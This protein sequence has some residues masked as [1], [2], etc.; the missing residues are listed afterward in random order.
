MGSKKTIAIVDDHILIAQA[1]KGIIANFE[2]FE[3][4]CECENGQELI[5]KINTYNANKQGLRQF[6][7]TTLDS[8]FSGTTISAEDILRLDKN[9]E[10][11]QF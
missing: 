9:I 7:N 4:I 10:N 5:D 2:D 8:N 11:F 1:I 3:T 6:S